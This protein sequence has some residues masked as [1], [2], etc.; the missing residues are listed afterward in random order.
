MA[1]AVATAVARRWLPV[2][3]LTTARTAVRRPAARRAGRRLRAGTT[4][5]VRGEFSIVILGLA[6]TLHGDLAPWVTAY[7][8]ILAIAGP[9]LTRLPGAPRLGP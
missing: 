1:T 4:L 7:V 6:G 8:F 2:R 3:H 5:I 9:F